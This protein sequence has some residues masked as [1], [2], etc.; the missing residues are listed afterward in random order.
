MSLLL[1]L[2]G[3]NGATSTVDSSEHGHA[4]TF[5][6]TAQLDTA[7]KKFGTSSLLVDGDSDCLKIADSPLWDICDNIVDD[8]TVDFFVKHD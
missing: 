5:V 8:W 6:G 2:N 4:I 1:H 7:E 3:A